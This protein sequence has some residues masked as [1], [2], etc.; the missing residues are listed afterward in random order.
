[1]R[2][3]EVRTDYSSEQRLMS[4]QGGREKPEWRVS[5]EAKAAQMRPR[6][7]AVLSAEAIAAREEEQEDDWRVGE[8]GRKG[9]REREKVK[10]R[11][12]GDA[13]GWARSHRSTVFP[14]SAANETAY[15]GRGTGTEAH[16]LVPRYLTVI[17]LAWPADG[18]PWLAR[19]VQCGTLLLEGKGPCDWQPSAGTQVQ[20]HQLYPAAATPGTAPHQKVLHMGD[21]STDCAKLGLTPVTERGNDLGA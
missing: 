12:V 18:A 10:R 19:K 7:N 21:H 9:E 16:V 14:H 20:R 2:Q 4:M 8:E 5:R 3:S 13:G 6:V 17:N 1:M 11:L 15:G